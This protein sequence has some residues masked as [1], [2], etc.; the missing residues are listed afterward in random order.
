[1]TYVL[2]VAIVDCFKDRFHNV[3]DLMFLKILLL[4]DP[5]KEYLAV[6]V[7]SDDMIVL[8]ALE[9]LIDLNDV[10]VRDFGEYFHLFKELFVLLWTSSN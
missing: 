2:L 7:F 3:A 8:I 5:I 1:M 10:L 6:K 9:H 4:V